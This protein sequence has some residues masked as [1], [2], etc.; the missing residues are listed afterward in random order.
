MDNPYKTKILKTIEKLGYVYS[1]WNVFSDFVELGALSIANSVDKNK[2]LWEKREKQYLDM[3]GKYKPDEQK[4][5]PEMFADL[6]DALQYELTWSNAP[7][8]ILGQIFHGLELHNKYK[9]QFFTPQH[10]CDMMGAIAL[11]DSQN[12]IRKN[13][14]ITVCEPCCGSGAMILGFC[15]AMLD[16]ELNYCTQLVVTATDIDLKCVYMTY[17]Q[18]SLYGIP[19]VVIHGN[20]LTVEAWSHWF[21]PVYL[22]YGWRRKSER[23]CNLDG[24]GVQT[25]KEI[26]QTKTPEKPVQISLFD[27]EEN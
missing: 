2:A 1:V 16:A 20:T 7:V 21:T 25:P 6:V 17:L 10:I 19:A 26:P 12:E 9:G 14:F 23:I 24:L 3:I 4:L 18:L 13:G 15:K 27:T 22:I 8:D 5:F 11:G